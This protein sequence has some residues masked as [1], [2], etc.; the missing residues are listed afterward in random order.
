MTKRET[1]NKPAGKSAVSEQP[2]HE[3]A[4][5]AAEHPAEK[6]LRQLVDE[7]RYK[8]VFESAGDIMMLFDKKGKIIDVNGK[9]LDINGYSKE[10]VVGKD[11]RVLSKILTKKSMARVVTNLLKRMAGFEVP[12][13][14]IDLIKKTGELLTFEI[15]AQPL[16]KGGKII[17][18]LGILRDVTE[19]KRADQ[20]ILQK[21]S[22]INL[23][24]IIN[25][26][27][28]QG[29]AFEE[30]LHLVSRE[31]QKLFGGNVQIVYL[32]SKVKKYLSMDNLNLPLRM[33]HGIERLI[34]GKIPEIKIKLK[35]G[36]VYT[37]I[38]SKG[39]AV[40]TNDHDVM[41]NMARE[42][43]EDNTLKILVATAIKILGV[44][45]T[46]SV[47]LKSDSEIIG[48]LGIGRHEAFTE[49]DMKRIET[50]AGQLVS[51]IKRMRTEKQLEESEDNLRTYLENAPDGVY[52]SDLNGQFLYVN[53]KTEGILGYSKEELVDNN[54]FKLNILSEQYSKTVSPLFSI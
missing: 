11:I 43:F 13:Y 42:C 29:K 38:L 24:N 27:A 4:V 14:E 25:E 16:R 50:I 7:K 22:D 35:P 45:S 34:G 2:A 21:S 33:A 17:G 18:D 20:E 26:A 44:N 28:N 19:R 32:L 47:P 12:P 54:Y 39:E 15:S 49:S 48:L 10:E 23:I 9:S 3:N 37:D 1:N 6:E 51:I 40:L 8:A 46:I 52:L 31:T 41:L 36:G 5:V 30:I 53:K